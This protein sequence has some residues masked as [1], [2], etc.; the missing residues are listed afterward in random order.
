MLRTGGLRP[1]MSDHAQ[2]RSA[3]DD[4]EVDGSP[5][6]VALVAGAVDVMAAVAV[7]RVGA[8]L[9][10]RVAVR[11]DRRGLK[12]DLPVTM[13]VRATDAAKRVAC[14]RAF[15]QNKSAHT[16]NM[17]AKRG[18]RGRGREDGR[19]GSN[20]AHVRIM[21][22]CLAACANQAVMQSRRRNTQLNDTRAKHAQTHARAH[23]AQHTAGKQ[24][25]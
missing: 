23:L 4:D 5:L 10:A 7:R 20:D 9:V 14:A 18:A 21:R 2:T 15:V 17:I 16:R 11:S 3:T 19:G 13:V 22:V 24:A 6:P 1:C 12:V 8:V 25:H